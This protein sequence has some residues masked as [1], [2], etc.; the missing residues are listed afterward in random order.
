MNIKNLLFKKPSIVPEL[1]LQ[2]KLLQ[3]KA[4][5]ARM[6]LLPESDFRPLM[7]NGLILTHSVDRKDH[8]IQHQKAEIAYLEELV[9]GETNE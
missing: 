3:A 8:S 2:D 6:E 5:L 9:K 7:M 1:S 4:E